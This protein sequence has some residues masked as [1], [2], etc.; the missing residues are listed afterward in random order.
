MKNLIIIILTVF[1]SVFSY[2][3]NVPKIYTEKSMK[4]EGYEIIEKDINLN[5]GKPASK[6]VVYFKNNEHNEIESY[7]NIYEQT[8]NEYRLAVQSEKKIKY[9]F[10][11]TQELS[12]YMNGLVSSVNETKD[13]STDEVRNVEVFNTYLPDELNLALKYDKNS[14]KFNDFLFINIL[15]RKLYY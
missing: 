1:F 11:F 3:I 6:L 7:M 2:S 9:N 12:S 5:N 14:P 10:N 13:L 4:L 15:L 8:N